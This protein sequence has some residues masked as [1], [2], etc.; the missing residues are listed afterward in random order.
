MD[1]GEV[2]FKLIA[3]ILISAGLG[4]K[5]KVKRALTGDKGSRQRP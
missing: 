3:L 1:F 2:L 4:F 5:H